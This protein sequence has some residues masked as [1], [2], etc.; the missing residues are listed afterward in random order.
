MWPPRKIVLARFG[1]P[2]KLSNKC[3]ISSWMRSPKKATLEQVQPQPGLYSLVYQQLSNLWHKATCCSESRCSSWE[4]GVARPA[5]AMSL[6]FGAARDSAATTTTTTIT[7]T[8]TTTQ[9]EQ[10]QHQHHHAWTPTL[11]TH[12][13]VHI[14]ISYERKWVKITANVPFIAATTTSNGRKLAAVSFYPE[15]CASSGGE[16]KEMDGCI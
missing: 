5:T 13:C 3:S 7:I 11:S 2:Q 15:R 10:Q 6:R 9:Q 14:I 8:T 4:V 16:G 12:T 1:F